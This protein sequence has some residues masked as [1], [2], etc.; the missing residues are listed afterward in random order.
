MATTSPTILANLPRARELMA[1]RGVD[2]L[3]ARLPYNVYYL[4]R[5]Q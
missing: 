1:Q 5:P 4:S 2:G 3:V